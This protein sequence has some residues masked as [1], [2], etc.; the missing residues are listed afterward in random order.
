MK[1]IQCCAILLVIM[2]VNLT[3]SALSL[4]GPGC[5]EKRCKIN[6][7]CS[8]SDSFCKPCADICDRKSHNYEEKDCVADC[9]DYLHD[10]LYVRRDGL[11]DGGD[12]RATVQK[13]HTMVTI[14]L[15]LLCFLLLIIVGF[16]IM[17]IL[18]WKR[19]K[20]V[21]WSTLRN[22]LFSKKSDTASKT[23]TTVT[24][25]NGKADL[26]L[27]IPGP[28]TQSDHS[29]VTATTTISRRPAEDSALDYAYDNPAM[30]NSSPTSK[31]HESSF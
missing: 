3:E 24:V 23:P 13:L 7:F 16:V 14:T 5:G 9:Q 19:N 27:E 25:T 30:T 31:P 10:L 20:N 28:G 21:T 11:G 6:E 15:I 17:R 2:F 4:T 22:K 18:R 26:R 29:P 1:S 8:R 12:L